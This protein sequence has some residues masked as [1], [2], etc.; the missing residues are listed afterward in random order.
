[1]PMYALCFALV[2]IVPVVMFLVGLMW[3]LKPPAFGTGTFVYRT[4]YTEKS[5]EVWDFAHVHCA[6]LWTR[7]GV[8]L[9]VL[10]AVLMVVFKKSWQKFLLWLLGGQ[11]LMLCI[12]VFMMEILIKNLFDENGVRIERK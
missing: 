3:K 5:P 11:M 1:M 7:Y 9:G 12:T 4:A 2:L 10:S 6:K 8:I